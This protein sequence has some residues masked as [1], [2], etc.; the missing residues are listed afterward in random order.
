MKKLIISCVVLCVA[1]SA[2]AV[3]WTN[4]LTEDFSNPATSGWTYSSAAGVSDLFAPNSDQID[5]EWSQSKTYSDYDMAT[6]Q[7]LDPYVIEPSSYSRSL[8]RVLTDDDTFQVGV[9]LILDSIANTTTF[10]QVANFGLYG[11]SDMGPDRM[12]VDNFS[13]NTSLVKD[14]SDFVEFNYFIGTDWSGRNIGATIGAHID[15]LSGEYVF[16]SSSDP[17]WHDCYLHDEALPTDTPLYLEVT[18]YGDTRRAKAAVYVDPERTQVLT[19]DVDGAGVEQYYWSQALAADKQFTLTDV[20]FFNYVGADWEGNV[21]GGGFG[22]FDD[23][24]VAVPEPAS[25]A[26]LAFGGGVLLHRRRSRSPHRR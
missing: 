23:L 20:A 5:A 19:V 24:Y 15:G 18:Y 22:S 9:T 17:G 11:L 6:D 12:M 13:G 4:I 21:D 25:L 10:Y 16:G 1:T 8:G 3:V 14:A 7:D 26:L 2:Q